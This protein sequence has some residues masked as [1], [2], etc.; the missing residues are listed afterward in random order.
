IVAGAIQDHDRGIILGTKSFGKGL[1]QTI[2]PLNFNTSIKITTARYFT[3]SGRCIQKIDYSKDNDIFLNSDSII[4]TPYSTDNK[5]IVFGAGGITPDTTVEFKVEGNITSDLLAKGFFF[6]FADY[7][8]YNNPSEKFTSIKDEKILENFKTYIS[9]S[10]YVYVS[11]AEKQ[12]EVLIADAKKKNLNDGVVADLEK[13]KSHYEG[14]IG[15]EF[16]VFKE[17]ILKELK[18]EL[19]SRYIGAEGKVEELLK[20]DN[21]FQAAFSVIS[22][23]KVYNKLLNK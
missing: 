15:L 14:N 23:E 8:Y 4:T 16:K 2:T 11:E 21:Q 5:R 1:V 17:E 3:P 12:L 7:Y 22:N 10:D 19:A 6:K 20:F 9:G 18:G 13:A